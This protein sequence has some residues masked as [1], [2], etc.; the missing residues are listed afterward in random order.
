MKDYMNIYTGEIKK[1]PYGSRLWIPVRSG[2]IYE[3]GS[4][5]TVPDQA[6]PLS[7][8]VARCRRDGLPPVM[9][10]KPTY[11]DGDHDFGPEDEVDSPDFD[12]ADVSSLVSNVATGNVTEPAKPAESQIETESK[13]VDEPETKSNGDA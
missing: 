9:V 10:S 13:S 12:L 8:I 3:E 5:L 7:S 2:E 1:M 11:Y 6:E 4:S